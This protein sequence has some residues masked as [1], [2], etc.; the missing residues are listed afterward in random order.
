MKPDSPILTIAIPT[1]NRVVKLQAQLERLL[2][3]LTT[4]V[5]LSVYDN[6]S[7]DNTQDLVTK[8]IP[9]GIS[10]SRA[11]TNRGAG[12]NFFRCFEECQ[13]EWLWILSD[14]DPISNMAVADL[15][16]LVRNSHADFI[17]TSSPLCRHDSD[18]VINDIPSLFK[19]ATVSS[20][21]WI[22]T[23]V[24]RIASFRPFLY[25]Y[26]DSISTWGPQMVIIL[27]FLE[28]RKGEVLICPTQL[29]TEAPGAPRWSTLGFIIRFSHV[30]EYLKEPR[31]QTLLAQL[32]WEYYDWALLAGLR[33][34]NSPATIHRWQR[35]RKLARQNLKAYG[36]KSP[37]WNVLLKKWYLAGRRRTLLRSL[38]HALAVT[39]LAWCPT[40]LFFPVLKLLSKP[41]WMRNILHQ[42]NNKSSADFDETC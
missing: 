42:G 39:I 28:E 36:A 6:A 17:H 31:H 15:L 25:V 32:I 22:S 18:I 4:E 9:H 1:Y 34:L 37:I 38:Q 5:R 10:Y 14:D 33:E 21:L 26:T 29:I 30:P 7:P 35:I 41:A 2:P 11:M 13:T 20:L 16:R 23:G 8:Y 40:S 24:Y 12:L 3:Q 27:A 19:H